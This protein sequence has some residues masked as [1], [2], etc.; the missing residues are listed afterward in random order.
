MVSARSSGSS[1]RVR[2]RSQF[3]NQLNQPVA[4]QRFAACEP[5]FGDAQAYKKLD[6]AQ[7]LVDR[8]LGILRRMFT[9]AAIDAFVIASVSDGDAQVVDHAPMA[10]GQPS[11]RA[12][13]E[14]DWRMSC[15]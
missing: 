14:G 7:V 4:Q 3:L 13:R 15:H 6:E 12:Q 9:C 1:Q 2:R 5:H 8:E 10:V 11:G